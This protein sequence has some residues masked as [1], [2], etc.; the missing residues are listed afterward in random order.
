MGDIMTR[1]LADD[2]SLIIIEPALRETS[3]EMLEVRDRMQGEGFHVYAPCLCRGKCPALANPKDWCHEDIPWDPPAVIKE[4][5][6]LTGLRKDS[7]KFSWLILRKDSRSL[8]DVHG[9][10]V[11]RVVSEPLVSKGKREFYLCGSEGRRLVT[12]LD[13]DET[14]QNQ[15]FGKIN[16]GSVVH[17]E[18]LVNEGKRYKVGKGTGVSVRSER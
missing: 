11:F 12:R 5:D 1:L 15:A 10:D 16:R 9:K 13:K 2:G 3:R 7:L 8:C 6:R 4:L 14:A 17:F 18:G